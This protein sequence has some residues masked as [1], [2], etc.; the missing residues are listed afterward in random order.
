[1]FAFP[2]ANKCFSYFSFKR[3]PLKQFYCPQNTRNLCWGHSWNPKGQ[4]LRLKSESRQWVLGEGQRACS[5][6]ARG[7]GSSV[8]SRAGSEA[9]P[10]KDLHFGRTKSR[11]TRHVAAN[12]LSILDHSQCRPP[13]RL[14]SHS[15]KFSI[16]IALMIPS[17]F[18]HV[19]TLPCEI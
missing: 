18:K 19:A 9:E 5:P 14:F 13:L 3:N 4:N 12:A 15:R 16:R 11:K 10:R 7:L 6:P 1:M 17:Y 8:S 2:T